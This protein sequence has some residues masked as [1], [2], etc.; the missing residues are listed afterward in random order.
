M[1]VAVVRPVAIGNRTESAG[2]A[3]AELRVRRTDTGVDD[4]HVHTLSG[5]LIGVVAIERKVALV[6]AVEPPG[7]AGLRRH[8]LA[9]AVL[10]DVADTGI[11]R[12]RR[13]GRGRQAHGITAKRAFVDVDDGA[14]VLANRRGGQPPHL[15][16]R[17]LLIV[18]HDD[19]LTLDRAFRRLHLLSRR[20]TTG[21]KPHQN[22]N[23]AAHRP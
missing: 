7:G 5:R 20:D 22:S 4:V 1:T 16:A 8:D 10:L 18:E 3:A 11:A 19:V 14:A 12:Q 13:R 23:R 9:D 15:V 17:D 2:H 6:D 21:R